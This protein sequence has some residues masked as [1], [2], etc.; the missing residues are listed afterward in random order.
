MIVYA[1]VSPFQ[2]NKKRSL[3]LCR[4]MIPHWLSHRQTQQT[5]ASCL[6]LYY[7]PIVPFV[8]FTFHFSL[9]TEKCHPLPF[10]R[11]P[12]M[13]KGNKRGQR[14]TKKKITYIYIHNIIH[15]IY[16]INR[17]EEM[18]LSPLGHP[19]PISLAVWGVF[20]FFFYVYVCRPNRSLVR[21]IYSN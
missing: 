2:T 18:S 20:L 14:K 5:A 11:L 4:K 7:T 16:T 17:F 21:K 6:W 15:D 1:L 9:L 13:N 19:H 8:I 3:S 10:Y 12:D